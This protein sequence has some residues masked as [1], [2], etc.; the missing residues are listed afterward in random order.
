MKKLTESKKGISGEE[1]NLL[2]VAYKNVVGARRSA[3]RVMSSLGQKETDEAKKAAIKSYQ[4]KIEDELDQ[5]C[6]EV[7]VRHCVRPQRQYS[8]CCRYYCGWEEDYKRNTIMI[9][10]Y[11][12]QGS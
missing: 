1:R 2:S 6:R 9:T 11:S 7:L 12:V 10:L 8:T 5:T 3:W 4:S